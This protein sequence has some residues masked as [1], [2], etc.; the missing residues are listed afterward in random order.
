M[1]VKDA[2]GSSGCED[3]SIAFT[4]IELLVVIAVIAILAALILPAVQRAT[5]KARQT[6]CL[7]H[8]RQIGI[9]MQSFAH[10]HQD[11]FPMQV[12]T[13]DGGSAEANQEFLAANT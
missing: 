11:R 1:R 12:P 8:L 3:N 2:N 10:D 13:R 6:Q 5:L 7:N 9:A 4:L